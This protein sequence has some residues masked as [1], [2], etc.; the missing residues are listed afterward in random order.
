[1][2]A[3]VIVYNSDKPTR[4]NLK[5]LDTLANLGKMML[6]D[7]LFQPP[8]LLWTVQKADEID[9]EDRPVKY[10][11]LNSISKLGGTCAQALNN[12]RPF[13]VHD[14]PAP[15]ADYRLWKDLP[16]MALTDLSPDYQAS[17][18]SLVDKLGRLLATSGPSSVEVK[19]TGRSI[20]QSL[21]SKVAVVT[22]T[23]LSDASSASE[24]LRMHQEWKYK[25]ALQSKIASSIVYPLPD[26]DFHK[27]FDKVKALVEIPDYVSAGS[28]GEAQQGVL[29][30]EWLKN[31]KECKKV[32]AISAGEITSLYLAWD[33]KGMW[34]QISDRSTRKAVVQADKRCVG[35]DTRKAFLQDVGQMK[36][37]IESATPMGVVGDGLSN[38]L[39]KATL[40]NVS[41]V[42]AGVATIYVI[43]T[44]G[45]IPPVV[46]Q[47][48]QAGLA[49]LMGG[50]Q[51]MQQELARQG[52]ARAGA[53]L[54]RR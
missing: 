31:E 13:E 44:R 29:D 9:W 32:C 16:G 18:A 7:P 41:I 12:F 22:N 42:A 19:R 34:A 21:D 28:A 51:G 27:K 24:N 39:E 35:T 11:L 40:T 38:A 49:F 47:A 14:M 30:D 53:A 2:A 3:D 48:G 8:P 1:M 5:A 15:L 20:A 43:V 33:K 50:G 54:V 25:D 17:V 10:Q 23:P 37:A 4:D 46:Q 36:E 26:K 45:E 52:M 6:A